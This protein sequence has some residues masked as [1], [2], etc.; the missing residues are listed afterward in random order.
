MAYNRQQAIQQERER[1]RQEAE[2]R[3]QMPPQPL[4]TEAINA[5]QQDIST[6][7]QQPAIQLA[8]QTVQPVIR[9]ALKAVGG[10]MRLVNETVLEPARYAATDPSQIGTP[11]ALAGTALLGAETLIEK[12][13]IGGARLA[14][15]VNVDPRIGEAILGGAAESLLTAG[16]GKLVKGVGQVIDTLPPPSGMSPAMAL[17][18]SGGSVRLTNKMDQL[19]PQMMP[20]TITDPK[21]IAPGVKEGIAKTPKYAGPLKERA[22]SIRKELD[23]HFPQSDKLA[24]ERSTLV[25]DPADPRAYGKRRFKELDPTD[26]QRF[27]Q[28]HHLFPKGGSGAFLERMDELIANNIADEDDLVNMFAF[29]ETLDL[30]MGDVLSNLLNTPKTAHIGAGGIHP[31]LIKRGLQKSVKSLKQQVSTANNAN[32]LMQMFKDYLIEDVVPSKTI[33]KEINENFLKIKGVLEAPERSAME[34]FIEQ[35]RKRGA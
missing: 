30:T 10:A 19:S 7:I 14:E 33:A 17:A 15:R 27:M 5:V 21:L 34:D 3:R 9:P 31:T 32:E 1:Q 13:G 4:G 11:Q 18:G 26:A 20:I 8:I 35:L 22:I 6:L 2:I 12:A 29:A 23:R 24:R 28:Q 16:A 25:V